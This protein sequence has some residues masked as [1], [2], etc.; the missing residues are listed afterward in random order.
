MAAMGMTGGGSRP[1]FIHEPW[2]EYFDEFGYTARALFA[3]LTQLSSSMR[4][5][6]I[7][8]IAA[9]IS[10]LFAGTAHAQPRTLTDLPDSRPGSLVKATKMWE[11]QAPAGEWFGTGSTERGL[12]YNPDSGNL[13]VA[14][15]LGGVNPVILDAETGA[16][17]GRLNATGIAGGTF[18]YNQIKATSDGQIFTAN[19]TVDSREDVKIYRWADEASQP[20]LIFRGRLAVPD[21]ARFGDAL[22]VYGS[23]TDVTLLLS[24]SYPGVIAK[25]T[26]DGREWV[27]SRE[28]NY[29]EKVGRGG[30]SS[31][32]LDGNVL[33][34][35]TGAAPRAI[36]LSDGTTEATLSSP[37]I[38][39]IDLNSVMHIDTFT[40]GRETLVAAGPSFT[41]GQFYLFRLSEDRTRL[42][43]LDTFGPFGGQENANNTGGVVFD[44]MG[45]R[46]FL[47]DTNN[48]IAAYRLD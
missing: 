28:Y 14:S 36:R 41:T 42:H 8:G 48:A 40:R 15:R 4:I 47:M 33:A 31:S 7:L 16:V 29:T 3:I 44:Q 18:P 39:S 22:G 5:R 17:R 11:I 9:A 19:L 23:G 24:G 34:S 35:G 32:L 43:L 25:L 38:T 13:I 46:L 21:S 45:K 1:P 20:M 6:P 27:E 12:T 2:I 30:F 10:C 26:F 37:D